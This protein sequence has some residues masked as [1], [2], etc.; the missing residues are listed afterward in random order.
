[1][2]N[3]KTSIEKIGFDVTRLDSLDVNVWI[4]KAQEADTS[5]VLLKGM[6]QG[7]VLKKL[8][9]I[10]GSTITSD[11]TQLVATLES[12]RALAARKK[13]A[14]VDLA[15]IPGIRFDVTQNLYTKESIDG[16][17]SMLSRAKDLID[18][19][20][21]RSIESSTLAGLLAEPSNTSIT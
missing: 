19:L 5:F 21:S 1:M 11:K 14:E 2:T 16:I 6:K 18:F 20:S 10:L 4:A 13:Q 7:G 17:L 15:Q 9:G 8:T 3:L 12:L